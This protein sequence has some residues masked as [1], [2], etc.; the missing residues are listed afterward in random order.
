MIGGSPYK[1]PVIRKT[2]QFHDV[3]L[4]SQSTTNWWCNRKNI[5]LSRHT[6]FR[7]GPVVKL[8]IRTRYNIHHV[9]DLKA[10]IRIGTQERDP[11]ARHSGTLAQQIYFVWQEPFQGNAV[12]IPCD[13]M[14][15][16]MLICLIFTQWTHDVII[17]SLIRQN[18]VATSFL[19]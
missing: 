7:W 12:F 16:H 9:K 14:Y 11:V 1:R 8:C 18:D 4:I 15:S 2:F 3:I 5:P 10:E 17:K 13:K 19:T 6:L